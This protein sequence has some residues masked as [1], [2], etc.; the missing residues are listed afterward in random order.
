ML[1]LFVI[2]ELINWLHNP[3]IDFTIK[4]C[5]F[6]TDKSTRNAFK[7]KSVYNGQELVFDETD[8]WN[9]GNDF[10]RNV[11]IFDADNSP[12]SHTGNRNNNY[13]VLGEGPADDINENVGTA[14]KKILNTKFYL[15][16]HYNVDQS[17]L[18]VN[19]KGI[20]QLKAN[21]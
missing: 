11:E 9:F 21:D 16:L 17:Y 19:Q 7:S 5:L 20:C 10:A 12:S 1:N 18:Y 14:Q 2:Y 13:L 15:S 3:R 8:S 4:N 6:G